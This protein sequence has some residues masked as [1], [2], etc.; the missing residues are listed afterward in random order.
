MSLAM[1]GAVAIDLEDPRPFSAQLEPLHSRDVPGAERESISFQFRHVD[2]DAKGKAR[3]QT[4]AV[5]EATGQRGIFVHAREGQRMTVQQRELK[6]DLFRTL[7][8]RP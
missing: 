6:E 1:D 4:F 5:F 8:G 2:E 7:K 3:L